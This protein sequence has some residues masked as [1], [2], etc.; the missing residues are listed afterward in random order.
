MAR[1]IKARQV[2]ADAWL[3]LDA[4]AA[5]ALDLADSDAARGDWLIPLASLVARPAAWRDRPGR[6]GVA[7]T[8]ADDFALLAP[9]FEAIATI[10]IDFAAFSDGRGYSIAPIL[11]RLGYA[12]ELRAS[13][14][15]GRDQLVELERVGFDVFELRPREDAEAALAAFGTFHEAY[16]ANAR[17]PVPL[18][19]RRPPS[20]L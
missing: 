17:Q 3:R 7:I 12:G 16:Q 4:A 8:P 1:V 20:L 18:F 19:R 13:G 5:D 6:T 15:V 11:R 10:A 2:T 9:H 14:D